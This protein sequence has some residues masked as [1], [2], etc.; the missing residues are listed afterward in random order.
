MATASVNGLA[1]K[2]EERLTPARGGAGRIT[3]MNGTGW[4]TLALKWS[5][6]SLCESTSSE[7]T[8]N[9]SSDEFVHNNSLR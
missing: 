8:S 2:A 4:N 9:Q 6:R 5:S 7:K 1:Q 3:D